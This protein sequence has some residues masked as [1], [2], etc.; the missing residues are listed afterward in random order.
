MFCSLFTRPSV[1]GSFHCDASALECSAERRGQWSALVSCWQALGHS[2]WACCPSTPYHR[3]A[4]LL[5]H[6]PASAS[7]S[8]FF[9]SLSVSPPPCLF[10]PSAPLAS[11][12]LFCSFHLLALRVFWLWL[13]FGHLPDS[14]AAHSPVSHLILC[15]ATMINVSI[16]FFLLQLSLNLC[17]INHMSCVFQ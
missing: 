14:H 8:A 3:S 17:S 15:A 10:P 16:C 9:L 12:F 11:F 2:L 6:V 7:V 1:K 5:F 4:D 13:A